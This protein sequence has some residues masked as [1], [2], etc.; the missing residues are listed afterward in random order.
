MPIGYLRGVPNR[1]VIQAEKALGVQCLIPW[2][3]VVSIVQE[4]AGVSVLTTDGV[5]HSIVVPA[6]IADLIPYEPSVM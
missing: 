2:L 3:S 4:V 5:T 1:T 6:T